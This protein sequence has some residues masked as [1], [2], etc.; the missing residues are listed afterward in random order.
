MFI[1]VLSVGE[2]AARAVSFPRDKGILGRGGLQINGINEG[3]GNKL[4]NAERVRIGR[5]AGR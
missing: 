1:V 5:R 2:T 3:E 4:H